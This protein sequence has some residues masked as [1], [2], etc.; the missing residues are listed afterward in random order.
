MR[1]ITSYHTD[2]GINK[3]TNQDSLCIQVAETQL[4]TVVL[5]VICDGMGGLSK[6]EL[7]SASVVCAF[8]QWFETELPMFMKQINIVGNIKI[9][10]GQLIKKQNQ[11]IAEYGK[12]NGIQLGTTLTAL[13]IVETDFLLVGHVGD[14]RVYRINQTI[15][16]ITEDQTVVNREMKRGNMTLEEAE[17]DSRRNVLLQ[18]IG[19]SKVVRPSFFISKAQ[20]G[21]VFVLCSDG[22]RHKINDYEMLSAFRSTNTLD[23]ESIR[24]QI[25][26]LVEVNKFRNENDNI[27]AIVIKLQEGEIFN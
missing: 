22:F 10:W 4:G 5:A 3:S 26:K 18:C 14:T 23:E 27:T 2:I 21:D 9:S 8:K 16:Q 20:R 11:R 25:I 24:Q 12:S 19:A 7:A 6:G 13:L 17:N 1:V 15:D